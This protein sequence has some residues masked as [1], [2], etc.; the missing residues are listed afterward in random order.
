MWMWSGRAFQVAGPACEN[1]FITQLCPQISTELHFVLPPEMVHS[2]Y[3]KHVC[4]SVFPSLRLSACNHISQKLSV[5]SSCDFLYLLVV[6][7]LGLV[8]WMTSY[9]HVMEQE[10]YRQAWCV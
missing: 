8:F 10:H 3:D 1:M 7:G 9:L 6:V 5:Q 2:S 4:I